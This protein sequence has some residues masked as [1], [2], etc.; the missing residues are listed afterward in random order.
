MLE[1]DWEARSSETNAAT[2]RKE[3]V[4]SVPI[5]RIVSRRVTAW[6]MPVYTYIQ[7]YDRIVDHWQTKKGLKT[8]LSTEGVMEIGRMI[9]RQMWG[10]HRQ[11]DQWTSVQH[12]VT[13]CILIELLRFVWDILWNVKQTSDI[14]LFSLCESRHVVDLV[15]EWDK[16]MVVF[17]SVLNTGLSFFSCYISTLED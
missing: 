9:E 6:V 4:P 13:E 11:G 1:T 10:I 8:N 7:K 12:S 15:L 5:R 14:K 2:L 3:T 16:N 17:D